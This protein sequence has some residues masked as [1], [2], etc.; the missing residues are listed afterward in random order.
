M[1]LYQAEQRKNSALK[2]QVELLKKDNQKLLDQLIARDRAIDR[3]VHYLFRRETAVT[4]VLMRVIDKIAQGESVMKAYRECMIT[5][6][7]P[8]RFSEI[9]GMH[10]CLRHFDPKDSYTSSEIAISE[11]LI[12]EELAGMHGLIDILS[13][14]QE[15]TKKPDVTTEE[16]NGE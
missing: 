6:I 10:D 15:D 3:S 1:S 8:P 4:S 2:N 11:A 14:A 7:Q 13:A 9:Q 5:R 12:D 16:N